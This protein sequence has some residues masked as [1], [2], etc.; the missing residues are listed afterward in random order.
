M[1]TS[2]DLKD[3]LRAVQRLHIETI[4]IKNSMEQ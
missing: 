2:E 3:A 4:S 1:M